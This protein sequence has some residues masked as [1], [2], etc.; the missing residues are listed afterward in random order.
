MKPGEDVKGLDK[1]IKNKWRWAWIEDVGLDGKPFSSW[2]QKLRQP[3]ACY[4]TLCS[5]KL[6]Y[7]TSGKKNSLSARTR[8]CT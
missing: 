5:K 3:G 2:C 4:C 7:G 6:M 1:S 8:Y